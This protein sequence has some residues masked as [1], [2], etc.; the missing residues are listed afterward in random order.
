MNIID[1]NGKEREI[2]D[3]KIISHSNTDILNNEEIN[4]IDYVQYTVIGI[5]SEWIDWMTLKQ[6]K[7]VNSYIRI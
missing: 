4:Q 1:T 3:L 2:K 6:F 5:N 7:I